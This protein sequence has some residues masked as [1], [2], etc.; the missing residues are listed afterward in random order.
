MI[1]R[2]LL[3]QFGAVWSSLEQF[4]A[5]DLKFSEEFDLT[6]EKGENLS[7]SQR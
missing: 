3:E 7:H 4:G 2:Y 5:E 6:D 1:I